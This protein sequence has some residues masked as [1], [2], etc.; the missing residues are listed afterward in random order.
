MF[1]THLG[2]TFADDYED[3]CI[4]EREGVCMHLEQP[5]YLSV[6][7]LLISVR[8]EASLRKRFQL[9]LELS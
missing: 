3:Y 6:F 5:K 8:V 2:V 1:N 7:S 9:I 4:N